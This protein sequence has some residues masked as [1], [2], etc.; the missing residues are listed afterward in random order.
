[1][2]AFSFAR[3]VRNC[4]ASPS[5]LQATAH[6]THASAVCQMQAY[7]RCTLTHPCSSSTQNT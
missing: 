1:L 4:W 2:A 7:C 6:T 5:D 3:L